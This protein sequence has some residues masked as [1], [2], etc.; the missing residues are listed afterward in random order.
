MYILIQCSECLAL[1]LHFLVENIHLPFLINHFRAFFFLV[2][3]LLTALTWVIIPPLWSNPVI[4]ILSAVPLQEFFRWLYYKMLK[5]D[6]F[7]ADHVS[8]HPFKLHVIVCLMYRVQ[9]R[10]FLKGTEPFLLPHGTSLIEAINLAACVPSLKCTTIV[11]WCGQYH[12][13]SQPHDRKCT[14]THQN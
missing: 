10:M 12:S 7:V 13:E 3:Y 2:A 9:Y 5:W 11:M 1:F 4:P 14:A 6:E 8:T